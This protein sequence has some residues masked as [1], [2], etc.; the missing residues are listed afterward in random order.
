MDRLVLLATAWGPQLGGIN[1][2]NYDLARSLAALLG[3]RMRVTCVVPAATREEIE[4][5]GRSSVDLKPL[6]VGQTTGSLGPEKAHE[7]AA[8]LGGAVATAVHAWI[9]HDVITGQVAL[10]LCELNGGRSVL[11]TTA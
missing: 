10:R 8:R 3:G 1:S 4:D 9:G 5:A 2:F 11:L 7:I 6:V